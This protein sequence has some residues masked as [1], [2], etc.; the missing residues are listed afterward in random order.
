MRRKQLIALPL[1]L[2]PLLAAG[3]SKDAGNKEVTPV[4]V[5]QVGYSGSA[6]TGRI[7]SGTI[8]PRAMVPVAFTVGGY[9]REI[10]N[11]TGG[12]G[13]PRLVQQGDRVKKGTMLAHIRDVDYASM[14]NQAAAQVT[15]KAAL[16][17][18]AQYG[19]Q[20]AQASLDRATAGIYDAKAAR[21]QAQTGYA[22]AR[23][24]LAA[25]QSQLVEAKAASQAADAL[26]DQAEAGREKAQNDFSR[27]ER[28]YSSKSLTR[29]DYDAAKAQLK[30][31]EAQVKAAKEQ[32]NVAN[33]KIEQA[34]VQIDADR[35]K[36]DETK[37]IIARSDAAMK[38]AV[39]QRSAALAAV[40]GAKAQVE[41]SA[42]S[43]R[44]A[45]A[46]LNQAE[47]PLGDARLK[48]PIDGIVLK[49]NVEIG[50]LVG[51]GTS[52]FIMADDFSVKVVFGVSDVAVNSVHI[53][54][55]ATVRI[56]A[57][58]DRVFTGKV[59]AVSP[60]ADAASHVFQVEVTLPNNTRTLKVGMIAKV[61]F[62]GPERP[63]FSG[64][65]VPLSAVVRWPKSSSDYA[66]YVVQ[67][68]HG[69][70]VSRVH[71]VVLGETYG[72][73]IEIKSG[74]S[75]GDRVITNGATLVRD[76]GFVK[77]VK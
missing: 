14:V 30:V 4:M 58:D 34:K 64:I 28:L 57:Y 27:A 33:T 53:G 72:N 60:A 62:A 31:A 2:I 65:K 77:V 22:Q 73:K 44:A 43:I 59:T 52:G 8:E 38:S 42:A 24:G 37:A 15:G 63:G 41:A 7:Y 56:Q 74:I 18:Q 19:M 12:D 21:D 26:V 48:A 45:K 40:K 67:K 36:M 76:G 5:S 20:Q 51:P 47:T 55:P 10:L 3:C 50:N 13:Q 16:T 68:E 11:V 32:R 46:Q 54:D 49:R 23:A 75:Y 35:S 66:V 9:V 29:A 6:E 25:A 1:I 69:K 71:K 39:A 61:E 17:Q 70:L